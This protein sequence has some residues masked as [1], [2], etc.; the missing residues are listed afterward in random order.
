MGDPAVVR[1]NT[2]VVDEAAAVAEA[3]EEGVDM[4]KGGTPSGLDLFALMEQCV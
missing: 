3:V 4:D 1:H 2:V